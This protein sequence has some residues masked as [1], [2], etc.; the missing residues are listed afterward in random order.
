MVAH[1]LALVMHIW[2]KK[3]KQFQRG[4]V[5]ETIYLVGVA[6]PEQDFFAMKITAKIPNKVSFFIFIF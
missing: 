6:F 2:A 4:V 1:L 3:K 5:G